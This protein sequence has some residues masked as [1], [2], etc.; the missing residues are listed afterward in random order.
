MA[1]KAGKQTLK[2]KTAGKAVK[3]TQRAKKI[4]KTTGKATSVKKTAT[5][6]KAKKTT[7]LKKASKKKLPTKLA[8][9]VATVKAA[10]RTKTVVKPTRTA[11]AKPLISRPVQATQPVAVTH[12]PA[13]PVSPPPASA[14]QTPQVF[15]NR[16]EVMA[17]GFQPGQ[18]VRHRYEHWWGT[19]VQRAD[20]ASS[21]TAAPA[22]VTYV[23]KLDGGQNRD[24]IRP[25]DLTVS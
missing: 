2:K 10:P 14:L 16:G 22:P 19:I 20:H 25:E 23:V 1:K 8:K 18:R 4:V 7:V 3:K 13:A 17:E 24:D 15:T 9:K 6:T 11:T 21:A 5:K 12:K